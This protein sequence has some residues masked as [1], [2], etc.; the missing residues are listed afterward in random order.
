VW[1]DGPLPLFR[2]RVAARR[3]D[4]RA[5]ARVFV[6][7]ALLRGKLTDVAWRE[8]GGR[9]DTPRSLTAGPYSLPIPFHKTWYANGVLH[10]TS[11]MPPAGEPYDPWKFPLNAFETDCLL[12]GT[13]LGRRAVAPHESPER[14][15]RTATGARGRLRKA[16]LD[17]VAHGT[18]LGGETADPA[19]A[20][21]EHALNVLLVE[22]EGGLA[23]A[24]DRLAWAK[25]EWPPV[26]ERLK[27]LDQLFIAV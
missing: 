24:R 25:K 15:A 22:Q 16:V 9:D 23:R 6:L 26:Y 14:R 20:E 7:A 4:L 5:H 11:E 17:L 1:P 21:F 8:N 19:S 13:P 2:E 12:D 18:P 10:S 3:Q 27:E